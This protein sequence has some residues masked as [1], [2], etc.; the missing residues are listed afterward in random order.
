LPINSDW[1]EGKYN[2]GPQK[3]THS[4]KKQPIA[5]KGLFDAV[6]ISRIRDA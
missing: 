4:R 3:E 6:K 5:A 1:S 2:G